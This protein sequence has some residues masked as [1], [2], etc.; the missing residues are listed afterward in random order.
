MQIDFY[1]FVGMVWEEKPSII[2]LFAGGLI[3][4]VLL[5]IDVYRFKMQR[6]RL[7]SELRPSSDFRSQLLTCA[8][9][10]T[11]WD[12]I[13]RNAEPRTGSAGFRRDG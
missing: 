13:S 7:R 6:E 4:F 10:Y 8:Q 9:R 5:V 12:G 11:R 1:S 3:V 2:I